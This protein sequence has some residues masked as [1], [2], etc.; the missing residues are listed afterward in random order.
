[1]KD[2]TKVVAAVLNGSTELVEAFYS[3]NRLIQPETTKAKLLSYSSDRWMVLRLWYREPVIGTYK[4]EEGIANTNFQIKNKLSPRS[5]RKK[6]KKIVS[7]DESSSLDALLALANLPTSMLPTPTV[8]SAKQAVP[9]TRQTKGLDYIPELTVK[10]FAETNFKMQLIITVPLTKLGA[11]HVSPEQPPPTNSNFIGGLASSLVSQESDSIAAMSSTK[12]DEDSFMRAVEALNSMDK[13]QFTPDIRM[14]LIK[15]TE[16]ENGRVHCKEEAP[17]SLPK[18]KLPSYSSDRRMVFRLWGKKHVIGTYRRGKHVVCKNK[19]SP[20]SQ[21]KK[22]KKIVSK[23]YESTSIDALLALANLSTSMLLTSTVESDEKSS[24]SE[25][26]PIGHNRDKT[27]HVGPKEK[28]NPS[29]I[30]RFQIQ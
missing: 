23:E 13:L 2:C 15:T 12:D 16:P 24:A 19:L 14:P 6:S 30:L 5:Q 9:V 22:S 4:I 1:M 18:A 11:N 10:K 28:A 20:R 27:N 29:V 8:E 26:A 7:R 17:R 3:V 21:R 25:A